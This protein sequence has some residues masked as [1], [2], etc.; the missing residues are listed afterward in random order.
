[1][2]SINR[3]VSPDFQM[4]S[5]SPPVELERRICTGAGKDLHIDILGIELKKA[6]KVNS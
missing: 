1:L 2:G 6:G 5:E 4:G 3:A